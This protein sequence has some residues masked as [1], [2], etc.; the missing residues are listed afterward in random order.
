MAVKIIVSPSSAISPSSSVSSIPKGASD[1]AIFVECGQPGDKNI[2]F[3]S[4]KDEYFHSPCNSTCSI[5]SSY[6]AGGSSSAAG[7]VDSGV[8]MKS[9]H[10][11][12][13][14]LDAA[15]DVTGD[16]LLTTG[17]TAGR[18]MSSAERSELASRTYLSAVGSSVQRGRQH[19]L[20]S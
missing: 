15:E 17:S 18:E 6:G 4:P 20:L 8:W 9:Y 11:S 19:H 16:S 10:S 3:K 5:D 7:L 1:Q 2:A 14:M 13:D 12:S